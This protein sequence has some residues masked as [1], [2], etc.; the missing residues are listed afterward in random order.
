VSRPDPELEPGEAFEVPIEHGSL[1]L[2][3]L[4]FVHADGSTT[5][6]ETLRPASLV[7]A[8]GMVVG[9]S[10]PISVLELGIAGEAEVIDIEPYSA[11]VRTD[12]PV[13]TTRFVTDAAAVVDLYL[14]G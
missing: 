11:I 3:R 4:K 8:Q 1:S 9:R 14:E 12:V 10:V 2:V 6:I 13:V 7:N 5:I